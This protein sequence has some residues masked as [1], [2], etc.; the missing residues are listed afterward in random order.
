[1]SATR[2][3]VCDRVALY[4]YT[5]QYGVRLHRFNSGEMAIGDGPIYPLTDGEFLAIRWGLSSSGK[6]LEAKR[7][8]L[9]A[10]VKAAGGGSP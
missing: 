7:A 3:P 2:V 9:A 6:I 10:R 1:M 8:E 4:G 5:D